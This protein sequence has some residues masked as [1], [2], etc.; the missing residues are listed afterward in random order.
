[1]SKYTQILFFLFVFITKNLFAQIEVQ[2]HFFLNT[3]HYII[4][5][6]V[7]L[8]LVVIVLVIALSGGGGSNHKVMTTEFGQGNTIV[9][10]DQ[11]EKNTSDNSKKVSTSVDTSKKSS[12]N[13]NKSSTMGNG[14]DQQ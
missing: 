11:S 4:G 3:K 14:A 2:E 9:T 8:V 1:M 7:A 13:D 10:F 12:V 6:A 5:G